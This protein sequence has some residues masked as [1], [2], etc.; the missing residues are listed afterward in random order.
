MDEG[1]QSDFCRE[2]T[3][4]TDKGIQTSQQQV[5][6]CTVQ[7]LSQ[8][9]SSIC[10]RD[11]GIEVPVD[12]LVLSAYGMRHLLTNG[13]SNVL[14]NLAKGFGVM[15]N[16]ETDTRFPT[17]RMPMGLVEHVSNFFVADN[18]NQVIT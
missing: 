9:F 8:Q 5:I 16:D 3:G 1:V 7:S 13:Q 15:R 17:K 2:V 14:Y 11:F 10:R 18:I 6:D 4:T 12:F